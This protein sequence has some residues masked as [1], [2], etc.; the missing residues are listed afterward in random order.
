MRIHLRQKIKQLFRTEIQKPTKALSGYNDKSR[1]SFI[2][3]NGGERKGERTP[4]PNVNIKNG[5]KQIEMMHAS[6]K[7]SDFL[8]C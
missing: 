3:R 4:E 2:P 5:M 1:D 7:F 6:V 8:N